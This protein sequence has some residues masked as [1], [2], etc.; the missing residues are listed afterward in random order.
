MSIIRVSELGQTTGITP[1]SLFLTSYGNSNPRESKFITKDDLFNEL[2]TTGSNAFVGNQTITGSLIVTDIPLGGFNDSA[3]VFDQATH[4]FKYV[5]QFVRTVY[6]MFSQTGNSI[7]I[8]GTTAESTLIGAGIGTLQIPA[9]GF[10]PGD[11]FRADL[12]GVLSAQNNDTIRLRI[13]AANTGML[14]GDS[15]VQ[16]LSN[17]NNNVW[18]LSLNFIIRQIGGVGTA[19]ICTLGRFS[20]AK[21]VNGTVEGFSFNTVN[22]TTFNTTAPTELLITA[23][24]GSASNN[25]IMYSDMFILNKIY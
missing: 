14:L 6:G 20:Y 8:S 18:T 11:S 4:E 3:V 24:F 1:S 2:A 15:G 21:T 7:T 12:G 5:P 23:Q 9:N 13:K 25:N 16:T 19:S 17:V 10:G 22:Q